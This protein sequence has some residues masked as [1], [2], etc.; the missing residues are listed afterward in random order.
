MRY[1]PYEDAHKLYRAPELAG[2]PMV[3]R[4]NDDVTKQPGTM[5]A[6]FLAA[7][8]LMGGAFLVYGVYGPSKVVNT[9]AAALSIGPTE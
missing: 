5:A 6:L 4:P 1:I 3:P 8:L 2:P 7:A 9:E